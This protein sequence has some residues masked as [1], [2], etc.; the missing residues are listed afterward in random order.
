[1]KMLLCKQEEAGFQLNAKQDNWKGDTDDEHADQELEAHYI[2]SLEQV[3]GNPSQSIRTRRQLETDGEMCMFVLTMSRTEPKNNKE[4]MADFSWIEAMSEDIHQFK[5]LDMDIKTSFLNGHLKEEVHVNQPDGFVD[6]HHPDKVYC[7]KNLLYGLKQAP[8][9]WYDELFNFLCLKAN[10]AQEILKRHGM[11]SCDSVG[12]PMSTKPLDADLRGTPIDQTKY[13]SMVGVLM[14]L[15]ASRRYIVHETCYCARYQA[16]LTKKHLTTIKRIFHYLK[17]TINM[18]LW[19]SKE[20]GFELTTF[21]DSEH[22]G[23]LD[24]QKSTSGGINFLGGDKLVSWSSKKQDC[25]S[26]SSAKAEYVS[27]SACCAQVL[28]LRTQLTDYSFHFDK[29]PM[30][31][32][33]KV[34]IAISCNPVQHSCTKHIDVRY[35]FIKEHVEMGIVTLFFVETEYQLADLFTKA[36]PK[37]GLSISSDDL[38]D[39]KMWRLRIEQY[40]QVQD[41]ALCDVIENGNSFVPETQTTTAEGG[42]IITTISSPVTAKEK[43]KKKNDVKA[44]SMLLMALPNEYLMTF[45]QYKDAKSLFAAIETRLQKIRNKPDLDTMSI[46]DLYNNFIIVEQEVKGAASSNSSSQNMYFVS[47]PITNGTNEVHTAYGLVREDLE[48]IHEDNL[49]E[50]DLKWQLALLSMRAKRWSVTTA[51]RWDIL[52]GSVEDL[53]TKIAEISIKIALERLCMWKKPLPKLWFL[54]MELVLIGAIWLKMRFL[55]TWLLWLFQTLSEDIPNELKEYPVAP[56]VKD[57]VS[58]NKDCLVESLVVVEKKTVVLTIAKVEV[59]RP[60]QQETPVR[61]TVRNSIEHMLPLVKEQMVAELKLILSQGVK[62]DNLDFED[63]YFVKELKFN[64]FSV[65]QMCDRKNN[66]LFTDTECLV[67][68]PNFKLPDESQILLRVPRKNNMYSVDMKN[69][70]PK[71]SLTFLVAKVVNTACYVKNKVLVVKP[72]N[73]TPYELFR[74]RLFRIY[75]IRTRRVE[76]NLHIEFL[77]NKPIVT[78]TTDSIGAGQSSMETRSTQDYIFM[79]LW[80]D[81]SPLF[82]TSLKISSDAGK[83]HDKVS[84][85]ESRALN[86]LN[87]AFENLNTEYPDDPKMP[88]LET[89]K[90][91]ADF[92]KQANFTNLESLIH[93]S[94]TPTTR[95]QKNH[96]LKQMDVKSAFHYGRIEKEVYV[97]QP[98]RFEDRDHPDKV[99]KVRKDRSDLI[100]QVEKG[101]I[102]LVHIYVDDIIFGF[103]KK[104]SCVK[105]ERLMKDKFKISSMGKLTFFLG[106]Q[107]KQ[108]EN[109]I[110]I[111]QDKYVAEILRKFNFVDVKSASTPVDKTLVNDANDKAVYEEWDDRA[112]RDATTAASVDAEQTSGAKKPWGGFVAQTKSEMSNDPPLSRGHILE[113]GE[114]SLELIKKLMKTCTKLSERVLALE[115]SK[116]AQDLVITRLKLR[117]K[118]LTYTK[119]RRAVS[120][121]S[122]G[123]STTSRLFSTT[124]ELVS[125]AGASMPVSNV[126]MV[127]E[128]NINI[129]S[130]VVVKDKAVRLQEELD[131]EERQRMRLQAAER[132]KYSEVDQAK[133]LVD[134]INQRKRHFT[135]QK[136]EAKRNKPMTQAQ[137]R[138]YMSTYIKNMGGYTLNLL[139]KLSFD[140]IKK[141][142]ETTMKIVNTFVS[143]ET[144]VRGRAS[145]LVARSSKRQKTNEAS[146]LI[147]EQPVEE[148]NELSQEDLQQMMMVFPVEEVYV[149]A[150]QVGNHTEAYQFFDNMLKAFDMDDLVM[151]W[152]LVKER[153]SSTEPTNDKERTLWVEIKRLFKPDTDDT[154]WTLQ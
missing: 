39:Y 143:M 40:F 102:L 26:M 19:Y 116:T 79:P 130:P 141:L 138:A 7:L 33:S 148:E 25:T 17:N 37:I 63:V 128:V 15:T 136:A 109:G 46:D 82:D 97:C 44:K 59:V 54:L 94:P 73:K 61:K 122:G 27:L 32:D 13:R 126:G 151:L 9:A 137:Q 115:E 119:R 111:S 125:T 36:Y 30:Y 134:F 62:T 16:R 135:T 21:L 72:H 66:V 31:C 58:N 150:L 124:K 23:C 142:F 153:F 96:P 95:I 133:M 51:T 152:S 104:E 131:E 81:G 47:S 139:K 129:P 20:T 83:K 42:A 145:E 74:V 144:Q 38:G 65:L 84:D 1:E 123:I 99:Y 68:S 105:F 52:Q 12:T 64:L 35:H 41:Y 60:K 4:A 121:G 49:E 34:A 8:K 118:K 55:Q 88:G 108:K 92:E 28:W 3:I 70:V 86:E 149:E 107:V 29:M 93:I 56:L 140:E 5:R 24:S 57:R 10:Y 147:R 127:Q 114:D 50:M 2:S 53:G 117:V 146:G 45:N 76:E 106:L 22:V 75:N 132:N 87:S 69:I 154:L 120:T 85:K 48:Q 6:P 80:K 113:S 90:P 18:D 77:E 71:E 11:T 43:I 112:E 98:L 67:L 14:Y 110:F 103:T 101:D 89:I 100:Y 78:G 91:Y